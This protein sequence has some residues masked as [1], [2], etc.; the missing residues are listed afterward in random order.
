MVSTGMDGQQ[1]EEGALLNM[2]SEVAVGVYSL[3]LS[4]DVVS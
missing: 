4:C 1:L 3:V 2:R